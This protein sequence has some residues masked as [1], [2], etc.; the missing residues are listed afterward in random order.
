M[1]MTWIRMRGGGGIDIYQYERGKIPDTTNMIDHLGP[2]NWAGIFVDGQCEIEGVLVGS[3]TIGSSDDMW[4]INDVIYG[5]ADNHTGGFDEETM[6]NILGLVSEKNI[7]IKNNWV[8]GKED[9]SNA[10]RNNWNRH[11]IV[12]TA[13][14]VALGESFTFEHQNDEYSPYQ[15]PVPDERGWIFLHGAVTQQ[16]R[17]YVHRSN[18]IGTGYGKSYHYDFRFDR[19]PPP[20]YLEA[21]DAEGHG[22]FDIVSWGELKASK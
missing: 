16:R 6:D 11:S 19:R 2:P 5:G 8:N 15:G 14:M 9:G 12:I 7:I 1:L 22:L 20:Y 10:E 18:H 13:G 21:L 17:G 3:L 4:L